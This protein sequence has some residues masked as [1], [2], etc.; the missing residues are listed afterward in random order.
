[1]ICSCDSL[2]HTATIVVVFVVVVIA[3]GG[4]VVVVVTVRLSRAE[5][6]DS[7]H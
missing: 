7:P 6:A 3:K 4:G 5:E 1:M 2:K